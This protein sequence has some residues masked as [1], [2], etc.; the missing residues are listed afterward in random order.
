MKIYKIKVNGKTY[1]VELESIDERVTKEEVKPVKK[2][3]VKKEENVSASSASGDKKIVAPLQGVLLDIKVKVG[4]KV[5]KG[6][7]VAII[8]A[9]K[10]LNEIEADTSGVIKQILVENGEPVEFGQP[11]FVI[12]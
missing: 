3:E 6:D 1:K 4:D 2:E 5:K 11:L 10:L 8:E 9:M 7:T 12:G